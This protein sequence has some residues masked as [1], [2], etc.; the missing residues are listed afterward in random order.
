MQ[1]VPSLCYLSI[2][3]GQTWTPYTRC[4][5]RQARSVETRQTHHLRL[6]QQIILQHLRQRGPPPTLVPRPP[7]VRHKAPIPLYLEAESLFWGKR[8]KRKKK[9]ISKH[10]SWNENSSEVLD[11]KVL[12][13]VHSIVQKREKWNSN[14]SNLS[15]DK[16]WNRESFFFFFCHLEI[17]YF[18]GR[19]WRSWSSFLK[20]TMEINSI[21]RWNFVLCQETKIRIENFQKRKI[22]RAKNYFFLN[23]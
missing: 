11:K 16:L 17:V 8:K 20:V 1:L 12:F 15:L 18:Y 21:R 10:N 6:P 22:S 13:R 2:S 14:C 3:C 19:E 7:L 5:S 23:E 9:T 4:W